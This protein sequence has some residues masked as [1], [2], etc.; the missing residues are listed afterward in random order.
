MY[1]D[2]SFIARTYRYYFWRVR[3]LIRFVILSST[4]KKNISHGWPTSK[5]GSRSSKRLCANLLIVDLQRETWRREKRFPCPLEGRPFRPL[6]RHSG[7]LVKGVSFTLWRKPMRIQRRRT[8][9]SVKTPGERSAS[10][11][12]PSIS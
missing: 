12:A 2:F 9:P 10:T 4:W 8:S 3:L 11:G 6:H 7:S 5:I 1:D